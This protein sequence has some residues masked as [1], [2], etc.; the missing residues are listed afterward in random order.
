MPKVL[1]VQSISDWAPA[2][3]G[4]YAQ[5]VASRQ[6]LRMAGQIPLE[7]G[8]MQ[9]EHHDLPCQVRVCLGP[10]PALACTRRQLHGNI[11]WCAWS[12]SIWH[13]LH[14]ETL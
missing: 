4:P 10:S 14:Y 11:L 8:S 2:C 12:M 5:A 6:L 3:I 9:I 13:L 7:P 1:H